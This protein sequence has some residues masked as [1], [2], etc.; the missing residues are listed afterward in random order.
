MY[1][2]E[3][4]YIRGL[5]YNTAQSRVDSVGVSLKIEYFEGSGMH[6]YGGSP[7][8]QVNRIYSDTSAN[9]WPC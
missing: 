4:W 2:I 9:K 3:V 1:S 5:S 8:M 6:L 7:Y